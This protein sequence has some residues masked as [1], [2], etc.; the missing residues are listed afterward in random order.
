MA[1]AGGQCGLYGAG[2]GGGGGGGGGRLEGASIYTHGLLAA[3]GG[4]GGAGGADIYT[5]CTENGFD[6]AFSVFRAAGGR[7]SEYGSDGGAGGGASSNDGS[8]GVDY[9]N[10]GGGGG[11]AGRIRLNYQT[12]LE[13]GA[14]SPASISSSQGLITW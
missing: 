5:S 9:Y 8:P 7:G 14:T 12:T 11:A 6:G 10:A 13:Q 4:G 3:N 1:G 2:G